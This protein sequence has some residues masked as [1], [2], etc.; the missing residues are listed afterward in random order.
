MK[1][2]CWNA[3]ILLIGGGGAMVVVVG[4]IHRTMF[5]K[6]QGESY[7]ISTEKA[8]IYKVSEFEKADENKT[9]EQKYQ[10]NKSK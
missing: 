3:F 6:K 9:S 2:M 4:V 7:V 1:S 10:P 5:D 8:L